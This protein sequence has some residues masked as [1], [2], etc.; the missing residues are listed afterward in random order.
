MRRGNKIT[1][2]TSILHLGKY[3]PP[4][5]GGIEIYLQQ[6]VSHQTR[7]MN[8]AVVVANDLR[9]TQIEEVDGARISRVSSLGVL[10][11]M[12][13]TPTMAWHIRENKADLIHLHMPNPG[14]ALALL[15]SRHSGK[16]VVT[17]H[18]DTVGR[19]QL[20][21]LSDPLVRRI[22]ERSAA[23]IVTSERYL[24]SSEELA[25]F[26]DKCRIIPLGI[27][28][29]PFEYRNAEVEARI[30]HEYGDRLV[31]AVGRLVPFKGFEYLI[32]AMRQVSGT[33]L[34]IGAGPLQSALK[35][36]IIG[37]GVSEKVRMLDNVDNALIPPFYRAASI[38]VMPSITRAE[39]FGIVQMEAMA[40]G[41]PVINTDIPS[42][43]P[44]VSVHGKTGLTVP[45]RDPVALANAITLLLDNPA[46][47][48]QFGE[49][50]RERVREKFSVQKMVAQTMNVYDSVLSSSI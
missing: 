24:D 42:G 3:Y 45:P 32:R 44:E 49:A 7:L 16:L 40:S 46:L 36:C 21:R 13:M 17:H 5:M 9:C 23:I 43:V 4:H 12:P 22:M 39:S 20:R 50:A 25:R 48:L 35:S 41:V 19:K 18:S 30:K 37:C 14:A 8:V 11:S 29:A 15:A 28:P 33:L 1:A 47:R 31:L 2:S 26:R 38:F 6:L 34:L 27:D 10:A